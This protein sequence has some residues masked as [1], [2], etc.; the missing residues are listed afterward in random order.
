ML[1]AILG[2]IYPPSQSMH[3]KLSSEIKSIFL[4]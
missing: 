2:A 3:Q 4:V 1:G